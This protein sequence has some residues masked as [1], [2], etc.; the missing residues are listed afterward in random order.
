MLHVPT[1]CAPAIMMLSIFLASCGAAHDRV[2]TESAP[3]PGFAVFD[4]A[5][6][7]SDAL[8]AEVA[9]TLTRSTK[10]EFGNAEI[11][12]ARRV[13]ANDPGWLVPAANGEVCLVQLI[14][15]LIAPAHGEVLPPTPA[16]SCAPEA[17]VQAGQLVGTHSLSA[18]VTRVADSTVTGVVPDGVAAVTIIS[19]HAR[20]TTLDVVRNAYEAT[21]RDPVAVR[22]VTTSH[23]KPETHTVQLTTFSGGKRYVER[24]PPRPSA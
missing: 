18:S 24:E 3:R 10:P 22:F 15:P 8:P 5:P 6:T 21:V 14:Y 4:G 9:A 20:S 11:K 1:W 13:L 19:S 2:K 23:G 7:P 12:D 16:T 17:Q